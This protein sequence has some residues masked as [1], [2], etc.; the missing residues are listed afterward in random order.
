MFPMGALKGNIVLGYN[1]G[2]CANFS[3]GT[4]SLNACHHLIFKKSRTDLALNLTF[5]P[6]GDLPFLSRRA[7]RASF[8]DYTHSS[9]CAN[10]IRR[11]PLEKEAVDRERRIVC[12]VFSVV[13]ISII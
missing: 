11:Q 2:Y 7:T 8:D 13:L 5:L 9:K 6:H 10:R 1:D 12:N 4:Q 3:I